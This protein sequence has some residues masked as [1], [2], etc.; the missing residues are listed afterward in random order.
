MR[1]SSLFSVLVICIISIGDVDAQIQ[2]SIGGKTNGGITVDE[3]LRI[4]KIQA[5]DSNVVIQSFDLVYELA[6]QSY[7]YPNKGAKF[8]AD[9][10]TILH[11]LSVG[12]KIHFELI[13]AKSGETL[14]RLTPL[15]FTI[16]KA[17][18]VGFNNHFTITKVKPVGLNR[19]FTLTKDKPV[20][21]NKHSYD[22]PS[23]EVYEL[24]EEE[25]RPK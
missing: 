5:S 11:K 7:S 8:E 20:E 13:K 2:A 14:S 12:D 15:H 25:Y 23:T 21:F 17:K 18:T 10:I 19:H 6:G 16:T 3:L 22:K 9:L 4:G 24:E 1:T